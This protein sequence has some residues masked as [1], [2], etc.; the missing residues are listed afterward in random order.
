MSNQILIPNAKSEDMKYEP[1]NIC[2]SG[3]LPAIIEPGKVLSQSMSQPLA[4]KKKEVL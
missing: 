2:G 1:I 4:E 3:L